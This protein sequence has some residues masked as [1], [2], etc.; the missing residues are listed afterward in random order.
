MG[1]L[2]LG[3]GV[4]SPGTKIARFELENASLE[5]QSISLDQETLVA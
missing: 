1:I 5:T 2:S 3:P 4:E